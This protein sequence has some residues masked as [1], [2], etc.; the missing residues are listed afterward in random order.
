LTL[1][2]G[3]REKKERTHPPASTAAPAGRGVP[4]MGIESSVCPGIQGPGAMVGGGFV[5]TQDWP[6][7]SGIG[8]PPGKE[9]KSKFLK[10]ATIEKKAVNQEKG[11]S[12]IILANPNWG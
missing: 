10:L 1:L 4:Q 9:S 7:V 11:P 6:V 5:R 12:G 3:G 8:I 2:E